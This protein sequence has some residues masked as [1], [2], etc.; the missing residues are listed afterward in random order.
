MKK[1]PISVPTTH[2]NPPST[3][4]RSKKRR[5]KGQKKK[6]KEK[7]NDLRLSLALTAG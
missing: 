5:G 7:K 6:K 2:I 3:K 4:K 1:P